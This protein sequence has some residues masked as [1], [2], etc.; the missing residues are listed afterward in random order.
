MQTLNDVVLLKKIVGLQF[1]DSSLI[2]AIFEREVPD[3]VI[4]RK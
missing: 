3:N 4:A 2:I 1:L